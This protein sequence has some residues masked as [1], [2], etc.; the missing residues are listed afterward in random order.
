MFT[1]Y[2]FSLSVCAAASLAK[3]PR[4]RHVTLRHALDAA[5]AAAQSGRQHKFR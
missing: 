5:L 4:Y 2:N 1:E 3:Q